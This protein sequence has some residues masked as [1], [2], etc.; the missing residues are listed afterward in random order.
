MSGEPHVTRRAYCQEAKEMWPFNN[1][2]P[3]RTIVADIS[4]NEDG[5]INV[6]VRGQTCPGY[7]LSINKAMDQL[8]KGARARLLTTYAPCGDD[9]KTWCDKKG[10]TCESIVQEAGMWKIAVTK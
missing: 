7:L 2:E 1:R 4:T 8:E 9:V 5:S 6:D 3:Y 10:Y